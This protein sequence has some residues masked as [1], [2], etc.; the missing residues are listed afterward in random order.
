[1]LSPS[2]FYHYLFLYLFFMTPRAPWLR[3]IGTVLL[4]SLCAESSAQLEDVSLDYLMQSSTFGSLFGCGLSTVDFNGDGLDDVTIGGANGIVR[5]YAA[6]D[7]GFELF[8]ELDLV[9][10]VKALLWVD[11]DN[12]GDLD[13][14]AGAFG[15]GV[16]LFI[17]QP[18]G[19]LIE[20]G[21]N[22]GIPLLPGWDNRGISARDYDRD[23]DLDI[24][25]ASYH[26][27]MQ[28]LPYEN[29]LFQNS[30][31][32][33][34][35]ETT[36]LAS[37]GNGYQHSFQ[38]AWFDY[39]NNGFDDLWVINDRLVFLNTLYANPGGGPFVDISESSGAN[40]SVNAMSATLFDPDNDGDWDQYVTNVENLPNAFMRNTNG[41]FEDVAESAGVASMQYGWGTCAIDVDGD[42]WDDMMVATYRFPNTLP[43]DNHL[44]MNDGTGMS[45][46][47]VT[48]DWPNEQF[49]LYCLGRLDLD[50]DLVP[51]I[52][53]H[54]NAQSP[55]VLRLTNPMDNN[56]L[57]VD[58]VGTE[59]NTR[60]V[61]AVIK[62]CADNLI[63]MKQVNA[64]EDYMTQ[65]NYT[66]FFGLG[67]VEIIDSIEVSWP[68][69]VRD[70]LFDITT[71]TDLLIVEG[72]G[73]D[74]LEPISTPCP[75][76]QSSWSVPFDPA[77]TE[78]TWNGTPVT[79]DVVV[80]NA[81]GEWTLE[82][83]WW[84]T[85]YTWSQTV[86]WAPE[87]AP[88]IILD[89]VQP[90]CFGDSALV[91]WNVPDSAVVMLDS[92]V[93][94]PVQQN[95]SLGAGGFILEVALDNGCVLDTLFNVEFPEELLADVAL[96]QPP[97]SG[98][99]GSAVIEGEGGTGPL[100]IDAGGADLTA[101]P[102]GVVHFN[103]MDAE[104]C[105]YAD[106]LVVVSPDSLMGSVA[107]EYLGVSD[108]VLVETT[109]SGGTP[110]YS[111]NWNGPIDENGL[112][113][114]PVNLGWYVQD[115]NGCLDLGA[116]NIGPNPVSGI[117][118][119]QEASSWTCLRTGSS[120]VLHGPE[121]ERLDVSV[122][123]L[124]GR[125][126]LRQFNVPAS[127][128]LEL[129]TDA[130]VVV[131]GVDAGGSVFRWLR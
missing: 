108:S 47:D 42:R 125:L 63:Q 44:Y 4:F 70:V 131:T 123:D 64:G 101:L 15:V 54:G 74:G 27:V 79:S 89:V 34:F 30:G 88:E 61:G 35:E 9:E 24:Y 48:E 93:S 116:L 124:S 65:H 51:D 23:G 25:I 84:G 112:T 19:S 43:Y 81:P 92:V 17:Q 50:Q 46:D 39:D 6:G 129:W 67:Q 7:S 33:Y 114:A 117:S 118:I 16:Y 38:G 103:I 107:F 2:S 59:S 62:V 20:E 55:Q 11:I 111:L 18:D 5:L 122:Y 28:Q 10:E 78:M 49:Q 98:G 87:T 127:S 26:D 72:V 77:I 110:P 126:V 1:M 41:W 128:G 102:S 115:S 52:V 57:T 22:R 66:Q 113:L 8:L 56:H 90:P 73:S 95:L 96:I 13:L 68:S 21:E 106:S 75:W 32:G 99:L 119:A 86:L 12:D 3:V 82:A 83:V 40:I 69:G 121:G 53:G 71:N 104:G 14:F 120:I 36:F 60:G 37:V 58:L 97:C 45:F 109:I 100:T 94:L 31:T 80:A 85:G 91:S 76:E 29:K 130:P 105:L